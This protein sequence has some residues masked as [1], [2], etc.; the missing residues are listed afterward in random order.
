MGRFDSAAE[1]KRA[2][3][4]DPLSPSMYIYAGWN[5]YN[6]EYDRSIEEAQKPSTGSNV[7]MAY[8]IL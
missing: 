1:A 8:N 4:I 5:F 6:R 7:T 2:Q 3:E